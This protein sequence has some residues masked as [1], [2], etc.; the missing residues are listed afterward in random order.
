ML[1]NRIYGAKIALQENEVVGFNQGARQAV[2]N[3]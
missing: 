2:Y 3:E 1:G